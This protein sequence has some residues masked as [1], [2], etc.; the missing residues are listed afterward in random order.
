MSKTKN[1]VCKF[2]GQI[3]CDVIMPDDSTEAECLEKGTNRCHCGEALAWS[4]KKRQA[5]K[6]KIELSLIAAENTN[7]NIRSVD[8]SI[9][10]FL[11][12]AID[13]ISE[14][15]IHQVKVGL[16]SGGTIEIKFTS[17][18]KITVSRSTTIKQKREVE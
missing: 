12:D 16:C 1:A 9:V 11:E 8:D 13:I 7:E 3:F 15:K 6:A 14:D 5:R 17:S 2:C 18:G 4:N 10:K